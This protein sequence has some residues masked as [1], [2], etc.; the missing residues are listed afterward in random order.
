[1]NLN[2]R[3]QIAI[4][5]LPTDPNTPPTE[6]DGRVDTL[7]KISATVSLSVDPDQTA[8]KDTVRINPGEM[9]GVAMKFSPFCGKYV[10]HCHI[11]E[12]EDHDMMR[13]FVVVP[14]WLSHHTN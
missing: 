3:Y 12:H 10:Y 4:E 6:I 11:L 1:M 8:P 7:T 13:P 9:I 5:P 14:K 2:Q